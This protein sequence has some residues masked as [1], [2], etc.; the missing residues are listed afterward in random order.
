MAIKI[1]KMGGGYVIT[2]YIWQLWCEWAFTSYL[3]T[4]SHK[5]YNIRQRFE[6]KSE[7]T[8]SDWTKFLTL[9]LAIT[10]FVNSHNLKLFGHWNLIFYVLFETAGTLR[11]MPLHLQITSASSV[12]WGQFFNWVSKP[13]GKN[14]ALLKLAPR[15]RV[16]LGLQKSWSL[17][18]CGA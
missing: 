2:C 18:N 11:R 14:R 12:T 3:P 1:P 17:A 10:Y 16:C 15:H 4:A 13:T 6:Q 5:N 7:L 9:I 8:K